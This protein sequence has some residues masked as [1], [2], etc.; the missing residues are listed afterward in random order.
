VV[1]GDSTKTLQKEEKKKRAFEK[2]SEE[3]NQQRKPE[4]ARKHLGGPGGGK[5]WRYKKEGG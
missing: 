2:K 4:I 5:G 1:K 3:T